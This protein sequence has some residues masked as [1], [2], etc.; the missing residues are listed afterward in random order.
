M[1]P[2]RPAHRAGHF[3]GAEAR[4]LAEAGWGQFEQP[5]AYAE[6]VGWR[7]GG[8]P[9]RHLESK[10]LEPEQLRPP[11][12]N[13]GSTPPNHSGLG[14]E[15]RVKGECTPDRHWE[16]TDPPESPLPLGRAPEDHGTSLWRSSMHSPLASRRTTR[17]CLKTS[18]NKL[19]PPKPKGC[20]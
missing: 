20:H 15:P 12:S 7:L 10:H 9:S 5:N 19:N 18:K 4:P 8:Y 13:P 3:L 16:S 6:A 1:A 17:P 2:P 11:W 14:S